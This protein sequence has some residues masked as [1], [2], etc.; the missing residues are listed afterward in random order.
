MIFPTLI[1]KID[2][3]PEGV[4]ALS[5][6]CTE[7]IYA[8]P[9]GWWCRQQHIPS[10]ISTVFIFLHVP[11]QDEFILTSVP[12]DTWVGRYVR[13]TTPRHNGQTGL[14]HRT[15]NGWVNLQTSGGEVAKRAY[16]LVVIPESRAD[17]QPTGM[18]D[19]AESACRGKRYR[20]PKGQSRSFVSLVYVYVIL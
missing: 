5:A 9:A 8:M 7:Y 3:V 18:D 10:K 13:I 1:F 6:G 15:G 20:G 2:R 16:N 19:K 12:L 11:L 14:V 17:I 4:K